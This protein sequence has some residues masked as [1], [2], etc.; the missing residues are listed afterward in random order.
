MIV[1]KMEGG[2]GGLGEEER[3]GWVM[4]MT[5]KVIIWR[6]ME[7][8]NCVC[9]AKQKERQAHSSVHVCPSS[10]SLLSVTPFLLRLCL[11]APFIK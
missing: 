10:C 4:I 6:P 3:F 9:V 11:L 7:S 5:R 2:G 1:L 8:P